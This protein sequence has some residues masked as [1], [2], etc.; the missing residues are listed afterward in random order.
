MDPGF[1]ETQI[2]INSRDAISSNGLNSRFKCRIYPPVRNPSRIR[3]NEVSVPAKEA[4]E[5]EAKSALRRDNKVWTLRRGS[6]SHPS[7]SSVIIKV[8]GD[9]YDSTSCYIHLL[10]EN[11]RGNESP[12]QVDIK[13]DVQAVVDLV[14]YNLKATEIINTTETKTY[15]MY[16]VVRF[17]YDKA[18]D[19]CCFYSVLDDLSLVVTNLNYHFMG[20][21]RTSGGETIGGDDVFF[22]S[23]TGQS[24]FSTPFDHDRVHP[25]TPIQGVLTDPDEATNSSFLGEEPPVHAIFVALNYPD[26]MDNEPMVRSSS[27]A[28]ESTPLIYRIPVNYGET[29]YQRQDNEFGTEQLWYSFGGAVGELNEIEVSLIEWDSEND[30]WRYSKFDDLNVT[31]GFRVRAPQF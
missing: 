19:M 14:N 28:L 12:T 27:A 17:G 6:A 31:I 13:G 4:T 26:V 16:D 2:Y 11:N 22:D 24:Y 29:Q 1:R 5:N 10:G 18:R 23:E 21:K 9:D 7:S 30:E 20:V 15:S 25:D 3:V 8:D